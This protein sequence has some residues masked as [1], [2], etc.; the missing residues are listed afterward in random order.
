LISLDL[1]SLLFP[2]LILSGAALA[3]LI[4]QRD[5]GTATL[6]IAL[7]STVTYLASGKKR[8]L[9]VSGII[10]L[11]AALIGYQLFDVIQ[12]RVSTWLNP[13]IDPS[14]HAYQIIQSL[15]AVA[16]GGVFGNGPGIGNPAVV[17]VAHSDFIFSAISEEFGLL[18]TVALII[19]FGMIVVRG[20]STAVRATNQYQRFLASGITVYLVAQVIL[21]IGG[22]LSLLPLTG[23]TL[24]FVSYGGS[25]LLTSFIS[26]AILLLISSNKEDEAAP[27]VNSRPFVFIGSLLLVGLFAIGTVNMYW[28]F[29]KSGELQDRT[30]NPRWAITDRYVPRG[31]ILDRN[32][33]SIAITGSIPGNFQ[34][35]LLHA[36]LG[37]VIGYSSPL[38]GLAGLEASLDPYLRGLEGNPTSTIAAY[39]L[40]H[41]Q[42]PP[43]LDVRLSLD[44]K[45]QQLADSLMAGKTGS[46]VVLNAQTGEILAMTSHPGF[47]PDR[48]DENWQKWIT[49]PGSVFLNRATQGQYAPGTVL[50]PFILAAVMSQENLPAIPTQTSI[51][52]N[53]V[54]WDCALSLPSQPTWGDLI[55]H[56]CPGVINDLGQ[57]L[58][59]DRINQL[60]HQLELDRAPDIL[61][62]VAPVATGQTLDT[63]ERLTLGQGKIS[64]SP[65]QMAL[66]A[67]SLSPS[68][69][70]PT[71]RIALAVHTPSQGWVALPSTSPP[72]VTSLNNRLE[73]VRLLHIRNLPAWE[74]TATAQTT[75][76]KTT[77]F[78]AGTMDDWKGTPLTL[79]LVLEENDPVSAQKMGTELLKSILL[80]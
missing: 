55:S 54:N 76:A 41:G 10:I 2:T 80:P 58:N 20:L 8:I 24:P 60:M 32:N 33:Q 1:I 47:N 14:G 23:V 51:N 57:R 36:P 65:L 48:L 42:T 44:M 74:V 39:H 5:L 25:S 37:P 62:P 30:D 13:W 28:G 34:R 64:V 7:Y 53:G 19:L 70:I 26:L 45:I 49:D 11:L 4:A 69:K 43:G 9:I 66:A 38:Y 17:P 67:A 15:I 52:F 79:A 63:P 72:V 22:N 50:G 40:L 27:I 18:G 59:A 68:G 77:W 73:A 46:M 16:A 75:N 12:I 56:G 3:I 29:V 61:L 78:L 6:F 71:P 31:Q 35:S 21:I